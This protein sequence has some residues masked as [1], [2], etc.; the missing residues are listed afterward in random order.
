MA[1]LDLSSSLGPID[2]RSP[3]VAASGTV[4]SI[5]EWAAVADTAPY[6]AAVAK[7]VSPVPWEGNPLPRMAPTRV[8]MLNSI[9]IQNP[10]AERWVEEVAPRLPNLE[11]DVW[12]SVVGHGEHEFGLA[13]KALAESTIAAVEVNLSCPNLAD[14]NIFSF[15]ADLS[16]SVIRRVAEAVDLPIGAK[17]SPNTPD[18]VAVAGACIESGA[19]FL[20]LTNTA[21]GMGLDREGRPLLSRVVGGYSGPGLKPIS[22]RCVYEVAQAFPGFPIV[23]CGGVMSGEDVVDY[24]RCG[25]SA[26]A[27]GTAHLADPRCGRRIER[28]LIEYMSKTGV[29]SVRSI[30]GEIRT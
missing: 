18:L 25:A 14:G 15:D 22:L 2:M 5:V 10:G 23:G 26:V 3:L 12:G 9:G 11:V 7:S 19:D 1:Q 17:L 30:I 29:R 27:I 16:G 6:G 8:G 28:E 4:G 20:T 21:L 13:A 24:L